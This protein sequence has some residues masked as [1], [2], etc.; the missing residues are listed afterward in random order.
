M[1]YYLKVINGINYIFLTTMSEGRS[2]KVGFFV[3]S[4]NLVSVIV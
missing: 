1:Q 3:L 2:A 4:C